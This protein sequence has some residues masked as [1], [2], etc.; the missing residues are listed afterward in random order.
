VVPVEFTD[1]VATGLCRKGVSVD[2]RTYADL[3]HDT[4]PGVVIGI[5]D[6]AMPDILDWVG[7]RFDGQPV[8]STCSTY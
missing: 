3:E 8:A 4:Y 7:G 5:T 2:Y 6:G 1:E